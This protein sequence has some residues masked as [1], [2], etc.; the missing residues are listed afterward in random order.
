MHL[1]LTIG[2][3]FGFHPANDA[4]RFGNFRLLSSLQSN[5][6]ISL[7]QEIGITC[8]NI[9]LTLAMNFKAIISLL[10]GLVI[11]LSQVQAC[12]AANSAGCAE[13]TAC[14]CEGLQ[15]CPCA[16]DRTPD[17]KPAPLIPATVDVKLFISKT[18]E[19]SSLDAPISIQ[20]AA[21]VATAS[22]AE[23]RRAYA[24]VPFAVA[25]CRFVI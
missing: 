4:K 15:S 8:T 24:G 9:A 19:S 10:L 13:V 14:C 1:T 18:T 2:Y 21:M 3:G 5:C 20:P 7:A 6:M 23:A 25:F 11:Q 22:R 12:P 16:S 17:Q